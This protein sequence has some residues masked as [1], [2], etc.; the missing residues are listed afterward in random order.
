MMVEEAERRGKMMPVWT[1]QTALKT[2][3][4]KSVEVR[5]SDGPELQSGQTGERSQ[6]RSESGKRIFQ[7]ACD[8]WTDKQI[9]R[10]GEC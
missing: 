4:S 9:T 2:E 7:T 1:K 5:G 3:R 8:P 6:R 10:C